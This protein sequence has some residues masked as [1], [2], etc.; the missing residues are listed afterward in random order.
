MI[1]IIDFLSFFFVWVAQADLNR[2]ESL[3]ERAAQL[4]VQYTNSS[5]VLDSVRPKS[6]ELRRMSDTLSE[7]L[8]KR[9]ESLH[10]SRDLYD[11]IEKV[12]LLL[13]LKL[14]YLILYC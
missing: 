3:Y 13:S 4:M 2:A 12:F 5:V 9:L 7:L 6:I 10:R 14:Q 11:R 1:G 8:T